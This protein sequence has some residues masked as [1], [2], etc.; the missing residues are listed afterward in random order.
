MSASTATPSRIHV[1]GAGAVGLLFAAHLRLAGH[2][3]TLLLRSQAAVD[4][5]A[6]QGARISV[7]NDWVRA[8]PSRKRLLQPGEDIVPCVVDGL[9][10]EAPGE[11]QAHSSTIRKLIIATKAQDMVSAFWQVKERLDAQ[12]TVVMLQNG[13]GTFEAIQR[14]FYSTPQGAAPETPT[15]VIGTNSHGCLRDAGEEFATHHTAMAACKLAVRPMLPNPQEAP[16]DSTLELLT[17]LSALPLEV[18]VTS[19]TDLH[20][21]LLLKLAA[22]AI[23]NPATALADCRNG[24][25]SP[26]CPEPPGSGFGVTMYGY[27]TLACAEIS[28]IY[29][30]AHPHLHSELAPQAIEEY[31]VRIINATAQNRSSMLQDVAS[32]RPTE[33]DWING[34]LLRLGQQHGVP[35]PVNSL[36]YSLVKLKEVSHQAP[37]S[38]E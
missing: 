18:S 36:L 9:E 6:R 37:S 3:V 22:N 25:M 20:L 34:F 4:R 5:F 15:F 23:I 35:T 10:T 11:H 8:H 16:P 26:H 21:Q 19:W 33:V 31:V 30:R 29:A 38:D 2:P 27:V 17:A 13:M 28:A 7:F 14:R 24:F 12:S 32:G 1:L